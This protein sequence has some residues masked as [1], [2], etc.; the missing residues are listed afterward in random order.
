MI[1]KFFDVSLENKNIDEYQI[2][3]SLSNE[4]DKLNNKTLANAVLNDD[5]DTY[6]KRKIN[7]K[8]DFDFFSCDY[9]WE[10]NYLVNTIKKHTEKLEQEIRLA[11]AFS[12]DD[13][14]ENMPRQT[15]V[16]CVMSKL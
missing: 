9:L 3:Y 8:R 7:D 2:D 4:G 6:N 15:F 13:T 16:D 11:I 12:W 5:W 14:E 1:S 10:V